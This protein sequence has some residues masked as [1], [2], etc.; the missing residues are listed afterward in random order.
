M[1]CVVRYRSLRRADHS[2]RGVLPS[3]ERIT[4]CDY[5]SSKM[6]R[7]WPNRGCCAM[8]KEIHGIL[9][10]ATSN[11]CM[12]YKRYVHNL[13]CT[14]EGKRMCNSSRRVF[15]DYINIRVNSVAHQDRI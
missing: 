5:E 10:S 7:P 4:G 3:V 15:E 6:R 1:L 13:S 2:S 8:V 9:F 12:S 14:A 11:E